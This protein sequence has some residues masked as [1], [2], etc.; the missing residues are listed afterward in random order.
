MGSDKLNRALGARSGAPVTN[1]SLLP[2][3]GPAPSETDALLRLRGVLDQLPAAVAV[4]VGPEHRFAFAN[5]NYLALVGNRELEGRLTAEALPEAREQGFVDLLDNV[6]ATGERFVGTEVQ[7]YLDDEAGRREIFVDFIY[8][9]FT[10][11]DG[12]VEGI[13]IHAVDVTQAV[14]ARQRLNEALQ[15][16][17]E[18]RFRR[19][20]ESM[21]DTVIIA[22]P[23][24]GADGVAEDFEVSFVNGGT[25]EVGRR[26]PDEVIGR[27]FTELWPAVGDSGLLQKYSEV[28]ASGEPLVLEDYGYDDRIDDQAVGGVFDIRAARVGEDLFLAFRD[29]TERIQRER[30]LA[31]SRAR[32]A[33]EHD[34]VTSLQSAL[35]PRSIPS[36]EGA[37]LGAEYVAASDLVEVGGDWFDAFTTADGKLA[38]AIG[39]VAGKGLQ[40][41]Q[42]MTQV[43]TAGRVAA[44]GGAEPPDVLTAQN[45]LMLALGLGPF[46]TALFAV[47]DPATGDLCWASAGHLPPLLVRPDGAEYL[48]SHSGPPLGVSDEPAYEFQSVTI[49]PG[50][51]VVFF[52]DGLVERRDQPLAEGMARL[53]EVASTGGG[54]AD[55]CR[56]LL[57]Q[58]G[59][60]DSRA[61]DV[62]VLALDRT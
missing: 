59:V 5:K 16:E 60:S 58:L 32:L 14:H 11:A 28:I 52:T 62:C 24:V 6:L 53:A 40:A 54:P 47:Y 21:I 39:D 1:T 45:G 22:T 57:S 20:I 34:V 46:A 44:L 43:R 37:A 15:R 18:D 13:L 17:Q 7:A 27:R 3:G 41:A 55:H 33:Q 51:R 36:V 48:D 38:L 4:V 2:E 49:D 61:D 10:G 8:Q 19:A 31:E 9:P 29:V 23:I 42:V 50:C 26:A 12:K 35:L 56:L 25:D 30:A